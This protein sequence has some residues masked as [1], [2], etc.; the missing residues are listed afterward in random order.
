MYSSNKG[1]GSNKIIRTIDGLMDKQTYDNLNF[2]D[3]TDDGVIQEIH[4]DDAPW[5]DQKKV[6]ISISLTN[7]NMTN[8]I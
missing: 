5:L 2:L 6:R 7:L 4:K 8:H 1:G 3:L